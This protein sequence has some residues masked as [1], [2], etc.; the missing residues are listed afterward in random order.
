MHYWLVI[1]AAGAGRRFG[2]AIPKQ[3]MSLAGT[4]VLEASL[5]IFLDDERCRGVVLPMAHDDAQRAALVQRL[6]ARVRIV[7]GGTQRCESVLRGL[8]AL[9]SSAQDED[10]VLVHD[11]V[12]PC[13]SHADLERLLSAGSASRHGALLAAPVADTV[14]YADDALCSAETVPRERLWR[15][16]TPQMFRLHQLRTALM[17][18]QV[19]GREPT[20][21]AQ[22]IEWLGERP[23]LVAATHGNIKITTTEDLA[24]AAAILAARE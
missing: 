1:P 7:T 19:A 13:L 10:W 12:R 24:I 23:L 16:L 2:S 21:E 20:D 3:H 6:P 5:Q 8:E 14:K 22:A 9:T 17:Q 15:A 11:A 18:A 4:T